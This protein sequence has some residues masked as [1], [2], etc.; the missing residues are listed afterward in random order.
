M[1]GL[2]LAFV[3]A[4][5]WAG[6]DTSR[7]YLVQG[8]PPTTAAAWIALLQAPVFLAWALA[9]PGP[10]P[11]AGYWLPGG[12]ALVLQVAANVL[13][14]RALFLSP[15]SLTIPFLSLTPVFTSLIA[16]AF[17]GEH[18]T[19][20]QWSG[21]A[22]VVAGALSLHGRVPLLE[23]L[24]REPG[25]L[26]MAIV[27][28]LWSVTGNLAKVSLLHASVPWHATIQTG[29]VGLALVLYLLLRRG[30][31]ELAVPAGPRRWLLLSLLFSLAALSLQLAAIRLILVGVVETVKRGV[32]MTSSVLLG[33]ALFGE[34][35]TVAK[36]V[37]VGLMIAGTALLAV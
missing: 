11:D 6:L 16:L 20:Q 17:L 18:P 23:A 35:V 1:S 9:G 19:L 31:R 32:G 21:I 13:F 4:F 5:C 34:P 28:L 15:L 30:R 26:M 29:G 37:A 36:V 2:A 25:S 14:L 3:G 7:K 33:R 8:I 24:R 27:A 12:A 10:A 22:L